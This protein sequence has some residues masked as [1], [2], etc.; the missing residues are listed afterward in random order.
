MNLKR[1]ILITAAPLLVLIAGFGFGF[2]QF[3][4]AVKNTEPLDSSVKYDAIIALT[5][6]SDRI[7]I[8]LDLLKNGVA[9]NL[10][11]SG[12]SQNLTLERIYNKTDI[13]QELKDC[14]ITLGHD[15]TTT[16]ENALEAEDWLKKF[17][18][19]NILLVTSNYHMPRSLLIFRSKFPELNI[20]PY[21]VT[22]LTV[23]SGQDTNT[24]PLLVSEYVKYLATGLRITFK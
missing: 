16:I 15:A 1:T 19:K 7:S 9:D 13:P 24:L 6:G 14:C 18:H 8:A 3:V 10:L 12:V 23:H 22:P 17:E 20:T 4:S 5:G 11:I 2:L 21:P